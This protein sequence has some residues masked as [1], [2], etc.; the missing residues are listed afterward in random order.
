EF[1]KVRFGT[2][3]SVDGWQSAIGSK[4]ASTVEVGIGFKPVSRVGTERLVRSAI[5][6]AIDHKRKSVTIV[7]KGN[8]MKFTEGGFRDWAYEA[9]EKYFGD[10]VYTWVQWEK[11]KKE[12]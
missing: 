5:Q 6:Y 9:A 12:K 8:I 2:K 7:H 10:K 1:K 3:E 11:T 4:D